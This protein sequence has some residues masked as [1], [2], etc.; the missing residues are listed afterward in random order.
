M[1]ARILLVLLSVCVPSLL[2][3]RIEPTALTRRAVVSS[4]F[5]VAATPRFAVADDLDD[6]DLMDNDEV[7]DVRSNSGMKKSVKPGEKPAAK[8]A[9]ANA[10]RAAFGEIV[11]ARKA[12]SPLSALLVKGDYAAAKAAVAVAPLSTLEDNLLTLVQSPILGPD[13]KKAIGTIKRYGTGAD[14]LIMFGGL[15]AAIK[16]SDGGGVKNYLSKVADSLD[17]VLLVCKSGGLK[18]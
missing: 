5:A 3:L 9:D 10:G 15:S 6:D 8:K 2:A 12:L 1:S 18:P 7:P 4:A 14:V 11:A 16:D 13:E 17:E